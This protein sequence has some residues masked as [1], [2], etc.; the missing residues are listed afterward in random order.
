[1]L[2]SSCT[3]GWTKEDKQNFFNSCL[4]EQKQSGSQKDV[5]MYCKCYMDKVMAKYP[6][7]EDFS[8]HIN[9]DT[10]AAFQNACRASL[11]Q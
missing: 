6:T 11:P 10:L 7:Y 1:M 4:E 3:G 5:E 2:L 8:E 9:V